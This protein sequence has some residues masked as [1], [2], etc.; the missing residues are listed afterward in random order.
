MA[1]VSVFHGIGDL[2]RDLSRIPA[3]FYRE[4]RK[5]VTEGA[6]VGNTLAR[7]DARRTAGTHGKHYPKAFTA[8]RAHSYM[9]PVGKILAEYGPDSSRDQGG[10]KFEFGEG[11]QT[12]PHL[13]L[14]KSADVIGPALHGE[15]RRMLDGFFWPGGDR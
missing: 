15:T 1:K 6:K 7:D 4:G 10:M 11:R 9:G 8:D 13:N 14:A 3:A 5:I 12:R 2:K